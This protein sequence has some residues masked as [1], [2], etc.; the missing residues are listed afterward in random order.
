[1][2]AYMDSSFLNSSPQN[3]VDLNINN[4]Y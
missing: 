1:M 3:Y 2:K 4:L